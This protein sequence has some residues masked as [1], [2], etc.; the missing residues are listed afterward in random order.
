MKPQLPQQQYLVPDVFLSELI[1]FFQNG[2]SLITAHSIN[3]NMAAN[4]SSST[5]LQIYLLYCNII[6]E[7]KSGN[8]NPALRFLQRELESRELQIQE[9]ANLSRLQSLHKKRIRFFK[10]WIVIL[11]DFSY[12]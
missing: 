1:R 5:A 7:L 3:K 11:T 10:K 4:L 2:T 6:R 9:D 12:H 8:Y